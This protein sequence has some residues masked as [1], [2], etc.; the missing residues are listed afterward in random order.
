MGG[1][2]T[3]PLK[4]IPANK[5][6]LPLF[7]FCDWDYHGLSIYSRIRGIF[8]EKEKSITLLEPTTLEN[9][10]PVDSPN[11]NSKWRRKEFS[12]LDKADFSQQQQH[13]IENLINKNVWVEEES[14]DLIN[15][16]QVNN[17]I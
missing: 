9:A 16:L 4:D 3:N 5:F 15:C 12:G 11:H 14:M 8:K 10:L 6:E 2:N 13:F 1:N 7:Y 17:F